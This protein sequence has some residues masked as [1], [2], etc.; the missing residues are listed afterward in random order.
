MS[1]IRRRDFLAL[2]AGAAAA[3]RGVRT[4]AGAEGE[5][6]APPQVPLGKSGV[7]LSRVGQGTGMNGGDRQSNHTRMG[8]EKFVRLVRNSYERGVTFFDTADLY[9]THVYFREAL[10]SI[11]REKVAILTKLWWRYDGDPRSTPPEFQRKSTRMALERFRHEIATDWIDIVLLHCLSD[12]DWPAQMGAYMEALSEAKDRKQVRAV[13]VSCHGFEALEAAA[14]HPWVEVILARI[15]PAG[16]AMDSRDVD[17]VV[18]VLKKAKANGKAVIGMK[19]YGEGRLRDRLEECL[20]FAQ[21]LG[22]LDAM[23][24]GAERPEEMD[25]TL[26][27]LAK[28]PAKAKA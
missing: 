23:T 24:I 7:V 1:T 15:N 17:K 26:R 4:A 2:A 19:I 16:V 3:L 22:V 9:G 11:P 5:I 21:E 18:S 20:R 10:R 27:L 14:E 8:F 13:G 12:A 25:E 6:P 28:H